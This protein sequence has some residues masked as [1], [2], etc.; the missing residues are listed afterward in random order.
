MP[1]YFARK[2]VLS[3]SRENVT[4]NTYHVPVITPAFYKALLRVT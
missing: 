3:Q 2:E 1:T 4:R